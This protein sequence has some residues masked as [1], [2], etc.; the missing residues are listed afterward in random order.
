MK[1]VNVSTDQ[2]EKFEGKWVAIDSKKDLI[3]AVGD[4]LEEIAPLVSGSV[5][6]KDKIKA[7][8][9]LVPRKDEGPYVL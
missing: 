8:A 5:K 9:Y 1:F 2:M 6:D 4:T 7:S 3:I